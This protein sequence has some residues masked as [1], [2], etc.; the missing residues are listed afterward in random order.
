MFEQGEKIKHLVSGERVTVYRQY[1]NVVIGENGYA[2]LATDFEPVQRTRE[3]IVI[4]RQS[5]KLCP[6]MTPYV[7]P[8]KAAAEVEARRLAEANPGQDFL[9]FEVASASKAERPA[10]TTRAA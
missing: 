6:S 9:V 4:V 8:N 3:A 5:G 10:A 2:Y 7:H 1:G